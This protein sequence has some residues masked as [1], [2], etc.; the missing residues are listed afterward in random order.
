MT[1]VTAGVS[2]GVVSHVGTDLASLALVLDLLGLG[3]DLLLSLSLTTIKRDENV[4]GALVFE[5]SLLHSEVLLEGSGIEYESVDGK[6]NLILDLSSEIRDQGAFL[7]I[8]RE[9]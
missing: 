6:V 1:A 3:V 5:T 9:L 8:D 7:N 2:V 4:Y